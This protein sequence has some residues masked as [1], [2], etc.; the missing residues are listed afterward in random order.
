[1]TSFENGLGSQTAGWPD[2]IFLTGGRLRLRDNAKAQGQT[3]K[4]AT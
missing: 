1:V 3:R 2:R 4:K